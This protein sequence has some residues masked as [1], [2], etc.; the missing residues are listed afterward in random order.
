MTTLGLA[1]GL[2][3]TAFAAPETGTQIDKEMKSFG[4][5]ADSA[6]LTWDDALLAGDEI[7]ESIDPVERGPNPMGGACPAAT[8]N[9]Q[10]GPGPT[11]NNTA[12]FAVFDDFNPQVAGTLTS[13][14]IQGIFARFQT[15]T[16]FVQCSPLITPAQVNVNWRLTFYPSDG[17]RLPNCAA[18]TSTLVNALTTGNR[19]IFSNEPVPPLGSRG[20]TAT[21]STSGT[22]GAAMFTR[23]IVAFNLG[24]GLALNANTCY[25]V[26]VQYQAPGTCWFLWEQQ[27]ATDTAGDNLGTQVEN[28]DQ[29]DLDRCPNLGDLRTFEFTMCFNVA[30]QSGANP[31]PGGTCP[32]FAPPANG[33]CAT[34]ITVP[35]ETEVVVNN[36]LEPNNPLDPIQSC[37]TRGNRPFATVW[38]QIRPDGD[39]GGNVTIDTCNTQG[40]SRD[41][42]ITIYRINNPGDVCNSLVEI[43]CNDDGCEGPAPGGGANFLSQLCVSNLSL[44]QDYVV[45]LATFNNTS[46]RG[47]YNVRVRCPGPILPPANDECDMATNITFPAPPSLQSVTRSDTTSCAGVDPLAYDCGDETNGVGPGVWYTITGNGNTF[48]VSLCN[49]GTAFDTQISVYCGP[50]AAPVCV[51]GGDDT[52]PCAPQTELEFCTVPGTVYRILISGFFAAGPFTVTFADTLTACT[53]MPPQNCTICTIPACPPGSIAEAEVCFTNTNGGCNSTPVAFET[54][55][56]CNITLC[57]TCWAAFGVRDTD[58]FTFNLPQRSIVT[59]DVQA[60]FE[61]FTFILNDQ[62]GAAQVQFGLGGASE[63]CAVA[64]DSALL[65]PGNYVVF[66]SNNGFNGFPCG[67]PSNFIGTL[68]CD[69]I[70]CCV[71]SAGPPQDCCFTTEADCALLNGTWSESVTGTTVTYSNTNC[72]AMF[73]GPAGTALV[74]DDDDGELVNIPFAFKFFNELQNDVGVISNGFVGF[75]GFIIAAPVAIPTA[76]VPDGFVAGYLRDLDPTIGGEI[77]TAVLGA[78]P[79]RRLYMVYEAVT[80]FGQQPGTGFDVTFEIVFFEGTDCI[81]IRYLELPSD[82]ATAGTFTAGIESLLGDAGFD[83]TAAAVGGQLCFEFCPTVSCDCTTGG[84]NQA[85]C[86]TDGTCQN[87]PAP[88]C[89]AQS[90]TPQGAGTTCATVTCPLPPCPGDADGDRRV[91][92]G[93]LA[94][95]INNWNTMQPPFTNGDLDG[96][97]Q[98]GIGDLAVVINNWNACC[99]GAMPPC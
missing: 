46:N 38:F 28:P 37:D 97:G 20:L 66:V 39:S 90:G 67:G 30:M 86:F 48:R 7:P 43:G 49:P 98:V 60:E 76:G 81:Q 87:L 45:M 93:D 85:C 61:A 24:T 44:M 2:T 96:D 83:V 73:E 10:I 62:C 95:I 53:P 1:V 21:N 57:G 92:I 8:S 4:S 35:C 65:N 77:R 71:V 40:I 79:N 52:G 32:V 11:A 23:F 26:L 3:A 88:Q 69:P 50:C 36:L 17:M 27:A 56:G 6:E 5:Y 78:A 9:C 41:S 74:L 25:W 31:P 13:F 89:I 75:D 33:E 63:R 82:S 42:I 91:G 72:S 54:L 47:G 59:W 70:G 19:A 14:C 64:T 18:P 51:A 22:F 99:I 12:T 55:P 94:V 34:R 68:T 15:G 84:G 16:G 58:W 29:G 80:V